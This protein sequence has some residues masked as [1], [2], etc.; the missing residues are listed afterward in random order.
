MPQKNT[1]HS[2]VSNTGPLISL[3]RMEG[4]FDFA[5]KLYQSIYIPETVLKE[6]SYYYPSPQSYINSAR[7]H[8]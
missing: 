1:L 2:V 8:T 6:V 7:H 3:E 4:G 5:K